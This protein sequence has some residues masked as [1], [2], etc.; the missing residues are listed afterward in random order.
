MN[1]MKIFLKHFKRIDFQA[2]HLIFCALHLVLCLFLIIGC[3]GDDDDQTQSEETKSDTPSPPPTEADEDEDDISDDD[4]EDTLKDTTPKQ[5]PGQQPYQGKVQSPYQSP[6]QGSIGMMSGSYSAH[7]ITAQQ[8]C[9]MDLQSCIKT[10]IDHGDSY[11]YCSEGCSMCT[12]SMQ[13]STSTIDHINKV[14]GN[15]GR[16]FKPISSLFKDQNSQT[17]TSHQGRRGIDSQVSAQHHHHDH[18]HK[19]SYVSYPDKSSQ[20]SVDDQKE[21]MLAADQVKHTTSQ[22]TTAQKDPPTT[23]KEDTDNARDEPT[24]QISHVQP[25]VETAPDI[26]S[27]SGCDVNQIG[28]LCVT[29]R[30][31][32]KNTQ[33]QKITFNRKLLAKS[34]LQKYKK[35]G[36][37]YFNYYTAYGVRLTNSGVRF[38]IYNLKKQKFLFRVNS[39][40]LKAVR[41]ALRSGKSYIIP[42]VDRSQDYLLHIKLNYRSG[43]RCNIDFDILSEH[44]QSNRF[45]KY[46]VVASYKGRASC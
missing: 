6:H 44:P 9:A 3:S 37:D 24:G 35:F 8:L 15:R 13:S 26:S 43:S 23:I 33:G 32:L 14:L 42:Y 46:S 7:Q 1:L 17:H 36:R 28:K 41:A 20:Q 19:E 25:I 27:L 45:S 31:V 10:C 2:K 16:A 39:Y 11:S 38:S 21:Q 34:T 5:A 30:L 40:Q 4:L 12:S 22:D 29:K 18:S